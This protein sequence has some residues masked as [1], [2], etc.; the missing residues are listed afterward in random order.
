MNADMSLDR[1]IAAKIGE[2]TI[3]NVKQAILIEALKAEVRNRDGQIT[4]LQGQIAV[5]KVQASEP[6][7]PIAAKGSGYAEAT[8]H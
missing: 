3:A 1:I 5:L 8:A 7:L 6:G 2:L 4:E